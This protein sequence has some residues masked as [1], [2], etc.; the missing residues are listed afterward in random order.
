M[1]DRV[2]EEI[3]EAKGLK[4]RLQIMIENIKYG[5]NSLY[6]PFLIFL[7]LDIIL[8]ISDVDGFVFGCIKFILGIL[9]LLY[10]WL[11]NGRSSALIKD[12]H[13]FP[14]KTRVELEEELVDRINTNMKAFE[15]IAEKQKR[16][17][18]ALDYMPPEPSDTPFGTQYMQYPC[19]YCRK[20]KV[21]YAEWD[22]KKT[23][24]AFWGIWSAKVGKTYKCDGCGRFFN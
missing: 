3:A 16:E 9:A 18:E 13:K 24:I 20:Y 12:H 19:P 6:I 8:F 11:A 17:R 1:V 5:Y 7:V 4:N 14:Y 15:A 22:D 21:R 23:S 10:L 2:N